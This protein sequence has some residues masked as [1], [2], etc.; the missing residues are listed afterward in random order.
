MVGVVV[1]VGERISDGSSVLRTS[2]LRVCGVNLAVPC[3]SG[4]CLGRGRQANSCFGLAHGLFA[5][6]RR[7]PNV[8]ACVSSNPVAVPAPVFDGRL[9]HGASWGSISII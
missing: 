2:Q 1:A 7:T 5:H 9:P 6:V 4:L 3:S 8:K